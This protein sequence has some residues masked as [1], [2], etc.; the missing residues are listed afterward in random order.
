MQKMNKQHIILYMATALATCGLVSCSDETTSI[1]SPADGTGVPARFVMR[2]AGNVAQVPTADFAKGDQTGLFVTLAD[3]PLQVGGNVVNNEPLTFDGNEWTATK[4]LYWDDGSYN[5]YAYCPY[6]KS[7]G[8]IE[9]QPF[10][11][12]LDQSTERTATTPG[13]YEASD[14]LYASAKGVAASD[15][16]VS[17]TYKHM[18]SRLTIRLIKGEDFEG[19]MPTQATVYVHST[20]TDATID[21]Q[22]G[23]ATRAVKGSR[24]TI[25]A[26]HDGDNIYSAIV[27]PQRID[28]R[29]PL[30]EVVMKDMSYLYESKFQFKPGMEHLVNLIIPNNPDNITIEIGG[31]TKK[32]E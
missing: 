19:E 7:V 12:S 24:H 22:V 8:S 11:V 16:P 9:D 15:E 6:I 2:R 29:M 3:A 10:S 26:H 31:E 32:W 4:K 17:L 14:L 18:M 30:I 20:V 1:D 23:A 21:L 28:N 13:G 5:I 27:V 25:T